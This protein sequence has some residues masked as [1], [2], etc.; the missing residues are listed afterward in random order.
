[1]DIYRNV[2]GPS[3]LFIV[4]ANYKDLVPIYGKLYFIDLFG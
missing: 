1:M 2:L 3:E 4:H